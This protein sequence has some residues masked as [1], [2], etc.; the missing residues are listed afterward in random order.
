MGRRFSPRGGPISGWTQHV[1]ITSGVS[2]V[3]PTGVYRLRV[4]VIGAGAPGTT[5]GN[6]LQKL[7]SN[8]GYGGEGGDGGAG[9]GAAW[10][11]VPVMPGQIIPIAFDDAGVT[12]FGEYLS[13]TTAVGRTS[14]GIG[15]LGPGVE[16]GGTASGGLGGI[17][18]T[19][20][21]SNQHYPL[22]A[23]GGGGAASGSPLGDG[24]NGGK[25]LGSQHPSYSGIG[26]GAA[27]WANSASSN[28]A[29]ATLIYRGAFKRF[30]DPLLAPCVSIDPGEDG[31]VGGYGGGE[32]WIGGG[33]RGGNARP[34]GAGGNTNSS[35]PGWS[36]GYGGGGGGGSGA[37]MDGG[38][39]GVEK[40]GRP[41]GLGG[42]PCIVIFYSPQEAA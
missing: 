14:P 23:G 35:E 36:A 1:L 38:T 11:E 4:Y 15:I 21:A 8:G 9:G 32:G 18:G 25:G 5:G 3:V 2:F 28:S 12:R 7:V 26:G 16:D 37:P 10:G 41:G 39:S 29:P 40:Q 31:A 33:A 6:G 24:G 19:P 42:P 20:G 13:A 34:P 30:T 22:S 27:A 17:G